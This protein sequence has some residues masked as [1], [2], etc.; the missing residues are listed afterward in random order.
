MTTYLLALVIALLAGVA[1]ILLSDAIR[2]KRRVQRRLQ[3]F[4]EMLGTAEAGEQ[5]VDVGMSTDAPANNML[6][7]LLV[8]RFP[9]V[10]GAKAGLIGAGVA[11]LTLA[12]LTAALVF[13]QLAPVLA[14]LLA[15]CVALGAGYAVAIAME[16]AQQESYNDRFLLATEDL[17]RMV[18]FGIP[19][20]QALNSVTDAA[21]APLKASLRNVLLDAGLG[22]PLEQAMAREA[23]RVRM[24]C[25][26]MLA[27]ILATQ[28]STGGNLSESLGNIATM[29]RER[30]DNRAKMRAITAESKVTLLVLG[31]V[32]LAAIA[33]QW[34]VQPEL[35]NVLFTDGRHLLGIGVALI[36]AAFVVSW[37]MIRSAQR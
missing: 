24:G 17:Q 20:L 37:L 32:P 6:L 12:L 31:L 18:R 11:V 36:A 1:G 7:A 14:V 22:V 34:R 3:S 10:G 27:A 23:H 28:A 15:L 29:L 21:E 9:L 35:V 4:G 33:I 8:A 25:L 26:A 30:R 2:N 13:L 5:P 19:T 16:S